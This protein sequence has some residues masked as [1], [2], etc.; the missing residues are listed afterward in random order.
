[1]PTAKKYSPRRRGQTAAGT[2][3]FLKNLIMFQ[4][5]KVIKQ[6]KCKFYIITKKEDNFYLCNA[7]TTTHVCDFVHW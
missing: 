5:D 7:F 1:M 2:N 3:I 4:L 6:F